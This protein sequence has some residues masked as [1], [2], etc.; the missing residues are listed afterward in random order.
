M[1]LEK[2]LAMS[3]ALG[4]ETRLGIYRYLTT[5]NHAVPVSEVAQAFSLHP[6]AARAHLAR[7][8]QAGL[9]S[10]ALDRDSGSGRPPRLYRAT[11]RG[12]AP[13]FEPAAYRAVLA[14]LLELLAEEGLAQAGRMHA[15]GQRWG[16]GY[17]GRW[18]RDGKVEEMGPEFVAAGLLRT[19]EGWGF[20][21]QVAADDPLCLDLRRCPFEDLAQRFPETLCPLVEGVLDG[22][23]GAVRRDLSIVRRC[24]PG[25]AQGVCCRL[26]IVPRGESS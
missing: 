11:A 26:A 10:S 7:L 25:G 1:G 19:L 12:L 14:L 6:N 2:I 17:A 21:A 8:E 18:A 3:K 4:D 16:E 13:I 24:G 22:M 23:L 15:F 9:A 20:A 5:R